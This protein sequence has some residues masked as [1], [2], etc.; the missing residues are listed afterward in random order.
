[1]APTSVEK[2]ERSREDMGGGGKSESEEWREGIAEREAIEAK[3][4]L[5]VEE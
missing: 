1:M 4:E 5:N 3:R 2:K